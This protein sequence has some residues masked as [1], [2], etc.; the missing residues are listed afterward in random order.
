MNKFETLFYDDSDLSKFRGEVVTGYQKMNGKIYI[1]TPNH[2]YVARP[3]RWYERVLDRLK[4]IFRK[5][6]K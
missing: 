4:G 6:T 2:T 1:F 3:K 5:W